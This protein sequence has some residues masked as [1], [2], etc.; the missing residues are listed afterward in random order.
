MSTTSTLPPQS[1]Q[2]HPP[3][4][5]HSIISAA[6]TASSYWSNGSVSSAATSVAST[7]HDAFSSAPPTTI[8]PQLSSNHIQASTVYNREDR[9]NQDGSRRQFQPAHPPA[10]TT[11]V[12]VE[13][14]QHPRR[15]NRLIVE[16]SGTCAEAV[17][18]A[19]AVA[20]PPPLQRQADRKVNFVEN[21]VGM[22]L[23]QQ[24]TSPN[25]IVMSAERNVFRC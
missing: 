7:T 22:Y 16:P 1:C 21:L 20:P 18:A 9:C 24:P 2:Y 19:S 10:I 15:S 11:P 8:I 13:Q 3:S 6:S 17:T 4:P 14:R 5:A 25:G 12:P 23:E